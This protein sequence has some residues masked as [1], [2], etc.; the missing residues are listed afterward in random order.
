MFEFIIAERL[1]QYLS[2]VGL[3]L[4]NNQY[5]FRRGCSID[6]ILL[7]R[8]L[9]EEAVSRDEVVSAVTLD[10]ANAFNTLPWS[11]ISCK[12]AAISPGASLLML[13]CQGI[14]AK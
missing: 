10:V 1:I 2:S 7:V 5:G 3:D 13:N 12:G 6:A 11:C 8:R 14:F 9:T 4:A